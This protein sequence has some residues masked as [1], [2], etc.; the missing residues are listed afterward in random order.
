[1]VQLETKLIFNDDKVVPAC[2]PVCQSDCKTKWED[3]TVGKMED[4]EMKVLNAKY[5]ATDNALKKYELELRSH[6]ECKDL[7]PEINFKLKRS[8]Y[9]LYVVK[10]M[11]TFDSLINCIHGNLLQ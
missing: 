3:L 6:T 9:I 11:R 8:V 2:L 7:L 10:K 4:E 1:M 5:D